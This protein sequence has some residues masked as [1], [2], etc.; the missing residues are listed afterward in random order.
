MLPVFFEDFGTGNPEPGNHWLPGMTAFTLLGTLVYHIVGFRLF[1]SALVN[2]YARRSWWGYL[3]TYKGL[4]CHDVQKEIQYT[5]I[6][7]VHHI[8]GGGLMAYGSFT[9]G[10]P[11]FILG[12]L[13]S[14]M[15][16]IHDTVCM[17][18]PAWPF[19]G[20]GEQ[21][22]VKLITVLL[23]HHTAA[24]L[25]TFPLIT[26]GIASN[27]HFQKVAASLL[28][29]GGVSHV[30]LTLSR[31]RN[32]RVPSEAWQDAG[33]WVQGTAF[34]MWARFYIFP[35][36]AHALYQEVFHNLSGP[37]KI[38]F[39]GALFLM[40]VFNLAIGVDAVQGTARRISI[41]LGGGEKKE[42]K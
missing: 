39:I 13:I 34:F 32:R 29:A 28:L 23:I 30:T 40:S 11:Y 3:K 22:D 35:T 41:A 10:T 2:F 33:I 17:L 27:I 9:G 37:S 42:H 19:G 26:G 1:R 6:L 7:A 36:E 5:S 24:M 18:L 8:L 15:D 20:Q 4:I 14:V 12:A 16:D 25:G 21:R 38:G 31:T